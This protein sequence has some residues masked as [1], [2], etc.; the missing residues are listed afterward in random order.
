MEKKPVISVYN[1]VDVIK[2]MAC[3]PCFQ[4]PILFSD[5]EF[6]KNI[7]VAYSKYC[8]SIMVNQWQ[9]FSIFFR[10][11]ITFLN[12]HDIFAAIVEEQCIRPKLD[13]DFYNWY[14]R[15]PFFPSVSGMG[16]HVNRDGKFELNLHLSQHHYISEKPLCRK[17]FR[18]LFR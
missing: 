9:F 5:A 18:I 2:L 13:R 4:Y 17:M 3:A 10:P 16:L 15:L 8:D 14:N 6:K 1:F 12:V 7:F 11:T